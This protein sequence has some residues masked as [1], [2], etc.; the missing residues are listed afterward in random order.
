[1]HRPVLT[2][3][4]CTQRKG[5][6]D[7]YREEVSKRDTRYWG[8]GGRK[9]LSVLSLLFLFL[10]SLCSLCSFYS[11]SHYLH[12]VIERARDDFLAMGVKM[13]GD[14][15]SSVAQEGVKALTRLHIPQSCR[16]VHRARRHHRALCLQCIDWWEGFVVL[17]E[18]E[19]EEG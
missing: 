18:E 8:W 15:L 7:I 6:R 14:D 4:T 19:G 9:H 3:H 2:S 10:L 16:V 17:L 12:G 13:E 1:M 5:E 11:L